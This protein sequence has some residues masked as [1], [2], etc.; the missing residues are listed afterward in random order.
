MTFNFP[1]INIDYIDIQKDIN[2]MLRSIRLEQERRFFQVKFWEKETKDSHYASLVEPNPRLESVA[3]HSWHVADTVLLIGDHF[4][5]L[6]LNHCLRLAILHDKMEM[7]IGDKSPSGRDG[8]G[9]KAHGFNIEKQ[10][11]KDKME[12][13]AINQYISMLRPSLQNQQGDLLFEILEGCS[14]E[15]L[16]VKAIDKIQVLAFIHIKKNGIIKD[17]H[18]RFSLKYAGKAMLY[19]PPIH[20]HF[21]ELRLRLLRKIAKVRDISLDHLEY[22][23]DS[24]QQDLF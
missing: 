2:V 21:I 12:K 5:Y 24:K 16:F 10:L 8:T 6:D 7:F 20:L 22:I 1:D 18:L 4:P 9:K 14:K 13:E 23:V 19:F 17:R 15:S 3:D 11:E